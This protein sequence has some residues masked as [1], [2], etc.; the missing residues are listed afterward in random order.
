M[1]NEKE[2]IQEKSEIRKDT[3]LGPGG[4]L[5]GVIITSAAVIASFSDS[6]LAQNA[7]LVATFGSAL[8]GLGALHTKWAM[9]YH[10]LSLRRPTDWW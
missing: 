8:T 10:N 6:E 5:V 3:I 4:F 1:N 9:K 2:P 7:P